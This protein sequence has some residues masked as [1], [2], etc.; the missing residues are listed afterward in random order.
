MIFSY[1]EKQIDTRIDMYAFGVEVGSDA[2]VLATAGLKRLVWA[3][4]H[5]FMIGIPGVPGNRLHA[6]TTLEIRTFKTVKSQDARDDYMQW[7][8]SLD[9]FVGGRLSLA[10]IMDHQAVIDAQMGSGV[11]ESIRIGSTVHFGVDEIGD[12]LKAY[13]KRLV[14]LPPNVQRLIDSAKSMTAF[15][16]SLV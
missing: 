2:T 11:S 12:H 15:G 13:R 1:T 8:C 9:V 10:R 4:P 5:F 3:K 16:E 6:A 14:V 7:D